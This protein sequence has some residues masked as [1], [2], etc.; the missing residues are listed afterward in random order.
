MKYWSDQLGTYIEADSIWNGRDSLPGYGSV[1]IRTSYLT[2]ASDYLNPA[3]K[4]GQKQEKARA[5]VTDAIAKKD[6]SDQATGSVSKVCPC[7]NAFR[8]SKSYARCWSCRE[9]KASEGRP[10]GPAGGQ[11]GCGAD[12]SAYDWQRRLRSCRAC[13]QARKLKQAEAA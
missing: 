4:V 5:K 13:R 12:V 8:T 6:L 2:I 7:G 1:Q 3:N 9:A 10:L 11:C